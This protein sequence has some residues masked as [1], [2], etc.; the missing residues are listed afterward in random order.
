MHGD[1]ASLVG[2]HSAIPSL[3]TLVHRPRCGVRRQGIRDHPRQDDASAHRPL[4]RPS[5]RCFTCPEASAGHALGGSDLFW[6]TDIAA[7]VRYQSSARELVRTCPLRSRRSQTR[8]DPDRWV[9]ITRDP[10]VT[11]AN[12]R[13]RRDVPWPRLQGLPRD[14]Q[15]RKHCAAPSSVRSSST[16]PRRR[17]HSEH[18]TVRSCYQRVHR[19][20]VRT[21]SEGA[22]APSRRL[23]RR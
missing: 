18:N 7:A 2:R 12:V 6:N 16:R 9:A 11:G 21:R 8:G 17:P 5:R 14:R 15:S 13:L 1:T 4:R 20:S 22:Q 19:G 3:L 23:P 10:H